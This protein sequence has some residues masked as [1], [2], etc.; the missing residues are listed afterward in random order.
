MSREI[1]PYGLR[2]PPT[3]RHA[4]EKAAKESRRSLNA[5]IVARL[6]QSLADNGYIKVK[7]S[8][9]ERKTYT[10]YP[11]KIGEETIQ[12]TPRG[13]DLKAL[14]IVIEKGE[15]FIEALDAPLNPEKRA[16]LYD[17]MYAICEGKEPCDLPEETI[18]KLIR[19]AS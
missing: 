9:Q 19:L 1:N 3:L 8:T 4:L 7:G 10:V 16:K 17:A 6:E 5:E 15:A 13:V 11:G 12:Y 2:M 14:R 18:E